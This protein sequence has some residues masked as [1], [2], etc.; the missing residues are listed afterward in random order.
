MNYITNYLIVLFLL[1]ARPSASQNI[2]ST[3]ANTEDSILA[4]AFKGILL[5]GDSIS[6]LDLKG[7]V[8][9]LNF[10]GTYCKPCINEIPS[11]N[12]L[13]KKYKWEEVVFI[14]VTEQNQL[15]IANF[16]KASTT[17]PFLY[18]QVINGIEIIK[19]YINAKFLVKGNDQY[20]YEDVRPCHIIINKKGKVIHYMQGGLE[21]QTKGL[22]QKID[23]EL[24]KKN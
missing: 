12:A 24:K 4:P 16:F 20:F 8:I 2:Y 6:S 10:W 3:D 23:E 7:K 22:E 18:L 21:G 14:A 17:P 13:T 19:N 5:N 11:L 9:V 1:L 15:T